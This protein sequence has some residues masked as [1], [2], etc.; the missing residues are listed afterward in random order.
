MT[1]S[2]TSRVMKP[3]SRIPNPLEIK[4]QMDLGV[5]GRAAIISL[6]KESVC[7][8]VWLWVCGYERERGGKKEMCVYLRG[9]TRGQ[10]S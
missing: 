10:S 9:V 7:V 4:H 2:A 1:S 8:A 3:G 6:E 5:N